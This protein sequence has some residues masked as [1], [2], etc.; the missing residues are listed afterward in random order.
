MKGCRGAAVVGIEVTALFLDGPLEAKSTSLI[1]PSA[2]RLATVVTSFNA[3]STK[4]MD[5]IG[6]ICQRDPLLLGSSTSPTSLARL[7]S[8]DTPRALHTTSSTHDWFLM[9]SGDRMEYRQAVVLHV[10]SISYSGSSEPY[11]Q[12]D[13][14]CAST[15][16]T[17]QL[18]CKQLQPR[19]ITVCSSHSSELALH[20]LLSFHPAPSP[21][22]SC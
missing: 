19:Y 17:H 12:K 9:R 8:W 7:P 22:P 3:L 1:I 14:Q 21:L 4:V 16:P 11:S 15:I 10:Y 18:C 6:R 5:L 2:F 13:Q 20:P